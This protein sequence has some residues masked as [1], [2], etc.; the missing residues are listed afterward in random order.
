MTPAV[1]KWVALYPDSFALTRVSFRDLPM[2]YEM[3]GGSLISSQIGLVRYKVPFPHEYV[4]E[5]RQRRVAV[6]LQR[7]VFSCVRFCFSVLCS[8]GGRGRG[9]RE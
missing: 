3:R 8:M 4:L 7:A 2:R 5:V 6:A 9:E 1:R